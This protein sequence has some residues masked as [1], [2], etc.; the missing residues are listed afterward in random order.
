[1]FTFDVEALASIGVG[2]HCLCDLSLFNLLGWAVLSHLSTG[3]G[4]PGH[5]FMLLCTPVGNQL[6]T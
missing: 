5:C 3:P 4:V 1:M 6:M 2:C